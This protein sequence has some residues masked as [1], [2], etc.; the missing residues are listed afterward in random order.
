ML[1]VLFAFIA[2][3]CTSACYAQDSTYIEMDYRG[4]EDKPVRSIFIYP[5]NMPPG[6]V[7]PAISEE[8]SRWIYIPGDNYNVTPQLYVAITN[9]IDSY[10]LNHPMSDTGGYPSFSYNI[11]IHSTDDSHVFLKTIVPTREEIEVFFSQLVELFDKDQMNAD[12][13]HYINRNILYRN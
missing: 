4:N 2:F 6:K 7:Q 12:L 3:M 5:E 8:D 13:R 9:L 10:S 1:K 11:Y